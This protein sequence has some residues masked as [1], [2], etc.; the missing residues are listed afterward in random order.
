MEKALEAMCF[1]TSSFFRS[2][3]CNCFRCL[4]MANSASFVLQVR[5]LQFAS[6][7]PQTPRDQ[8]LFHT[9]RSWWL[10]T[11]SNLQVVGSK[12]LGAFLTL[13]LSVSHP[14]FFQPRFPNGTSV[15]CSRFFRHLTQSFVI[16]KLWHSPPPVYPQVG[17]KKQ[18]R[19]HILKM[20]GELVTASFW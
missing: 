19:F 16:G 1:S 15:Y 6:L 7:P 18:E 12:I 9:S 14:L 11:S 3:F 2:S 8:S 13:L 20:T 5:A 4:E 17:L 10:S